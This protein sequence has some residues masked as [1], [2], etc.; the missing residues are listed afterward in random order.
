MNFQQRQIILNSVRCGNG[1]IL[2]RLPVCDGTDAA[3]PD[4]TLYPVTFHDPDRSVNGAAAGEVSL[5]Y[6]VVDLVGVSVQERSGMAVFGGEDKTAGVPVV[7]LQEEPPKK[8]LI[9][10]YL[11]FLISLHNMQRNGGG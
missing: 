8:L 9:A 3:F 4:L 7:Q 2:H 10:F 5:T 1:N 6:G 11:L